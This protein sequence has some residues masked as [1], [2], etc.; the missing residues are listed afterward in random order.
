MASSLLR[1]AAWISGLGTGRAALLAGLLGL[2]AALTLPPLFLAP[3]ALPAFVG[4]VWLLDG[5]GRGWRALLIAWLFAFDFFLAGLYW[6]AEAFFVEAERFAAVAPFAVIGLSALLALFHGLALWAARRWFW[7]G[8]GRVVAL[9]GFWLLAEVLRGRLLTGFPWNP[10]GSLWAFSDALLQPAALAGVWGLSFLTVLLAAAPAALVRPRGQS[11]QEGDARLDMGVGGGLIAA[12]VLL[13][14]AAGGY[15][16]LRLAGAPE[17]GTNNVEGVLL[18]IVQPNI[19]QKDKWRRELRAGH[20]ERQLAM[21]LEPGPAQ[22]SHIVWSET[23]V[24]FLLERSPG[25]L[26][27]LGY[28]APSGGLLITGAPRLGG[29]DSYWN[30]L[31]AVDDAGAIRATYDKSH[32]VPFGEYVPLKW[33][34]GWSKLTAGRADFSAGPGLVTL[35]LPGLPPV[36]PLICYEIIFSTKTVPEGAPRPEWLLNLTNDNWFGMTSGPHQHLVAARLRALEEGLPVIRAANGG[37]SAAIDP[38]GRVVAS[39]P[40]GASGILDV[41]LPRPLAGETLFAGLQSWVLLLVAMLGGICYIIT[42]K[43]R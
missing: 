9:A 43:P 37:I 16:A 1:L 27:A 38:Y 25:L 11:G 8:A 24:P 22:P 15:G 40:L 19:S 13:F 14:A 42:R 18:R 17:A 4:L 10:I 36:T 23:A 20:V 28:A 29:E 2:A 30:S 39:L 33:L 41:A 35:D 34:F 7:Q 32:L 26:E 6:V 31:H 5:A 12:S 21:S 3:L